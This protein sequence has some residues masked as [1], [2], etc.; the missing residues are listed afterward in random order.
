MPRIYVV[1]DPNFTGNKHFHS[2][3][4]YDNQKKEWN[5]SGYRCVHCEKT[6]KTSSIQ[7]KHLNTCKG[8]S[9]K[10]VK[11]EEVAPIV[12]NK[13]GQEW[14]P[15]ETN[16]NFSLVKDEPSEDNLKSLKN[17]VVSH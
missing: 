4:T 9:R 2:T 3:F 7:N 11:E 14:Q 16:Q 10:K 6:F 15:L 13:M 5:F 12:L 1:Q 8:L 17:T